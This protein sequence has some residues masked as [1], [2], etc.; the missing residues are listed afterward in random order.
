M[1]STLSKLVTTATAL[2]TIAPTEAAKI[3]QDTDTQVDFNQFHVTDLSINAIFAYEV[4][5]IL[6]VTY[7][8]YKIFISLYRWYNF[9]N[10]G[11]LK[12]RRLYTSIFC[13][14]KLTFSYN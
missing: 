9:H 10:L 1:N 4:I 6:L 2:R 3:D 11:F 12:H 13:L 14:T 7:G 8:L 5:F